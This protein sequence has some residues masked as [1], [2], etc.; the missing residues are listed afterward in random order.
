MVVGGPRIF[1]MVMSAPIRTPVSEGARTTEQ[2]ESFCLM[3][4]ALPA[5]LSLGFIGPNCPWPAASQ[6]VHWPDNSSLHRAYQLHSQGII[7]GFASFTEFVAHLKCWGSSMV[8]K[9]VESKLHTDF[10][11]RISVN[12][13]V[14][15]GRPCIKGT[16]IR[17]S[18]ILDRLLTAQTAD[19]VRR[20]YTHLSKEDI[21]AAI[22][23]AAWLS[24]QE[25]ER[26][27]L[28]YRRRLFCN[29]CR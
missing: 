8:R 21:A 20:H 7:N 26:P 14:C 4:A 12:P 16:P 10:L 6:A 24:H 5:S 13:K 17:V 3:G 23:Y 28:C 18:A 11:R 2:W 19:A 29:T 9:Q 27:C 15:R 22:G 25:E 1:V